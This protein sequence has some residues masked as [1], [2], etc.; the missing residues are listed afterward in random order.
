MS[1]L[2][3]TQWFASLTRVAR[4]P[5]PIALRAASGIMAGAKEAKGVGKWRRKNYFEVKNGWMGVG[6]LILSFQLH[7][8][9]VGWWGGDA[10]GVWFK[11]HC[12]VVWED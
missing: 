7:R 9:A 4:L 5:A 1:H 8:P 11:H 2:N 10:Y 3:Q 6:L 12:R